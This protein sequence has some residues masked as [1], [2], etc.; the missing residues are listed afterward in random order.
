MRQKKVNHVKN[1][2]MEQNSV[3]A[4]EMSD[5]VPYDDDVGDVQKANDHEAKFSLPASAVR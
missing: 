3:R 2:D 4:S 5:T 1:D